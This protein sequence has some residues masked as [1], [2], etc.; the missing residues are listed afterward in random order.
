MKSEIL[1]SLK[2]LLTAVQRGQCKVYVPELLRGI[3]EGL[4]YL[5]KLI[6]TT[7]NHIQLRN[8]KECWI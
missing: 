1:F 5:Q 4:A 3:C 6:S 8:L 2:V 7:K